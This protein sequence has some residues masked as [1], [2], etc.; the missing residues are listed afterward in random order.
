V[1]TVRIYMDGSRVGPKFTRLSGKFSSALRVAARDMAA[2]IEQDTKADVQ[3]AGK[4]GSRWFPHAAVSEGGGHVR[5]AVTEDVP[6]WTIFQYGGTIYGKPLLYFKPSE[7]FFGRG[8]KT[9]LV[10]SKHSVFEP[11]KFHIIEIIRKIAQQTG[12]YL[13]A[14]MQQDQ[15]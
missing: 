15:E 11:K 10:I 13:A 14:R 12:D 2:D 4:F 6:Y 3:G 1:T 7:G 9:P 5:I 8:S